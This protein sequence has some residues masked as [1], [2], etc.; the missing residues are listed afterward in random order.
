MGANSENS[1][2][3]STAIGGIL[4]LHTWVDALASIGHRRYALQLD[5]DGGWKSVDFNGGSARLGSRIW[6]I[7][8]VNL[9]ECLEVA[10]HVH[11]EYR[12]VEQRFPIATV[13]FKDSLGIRENTVHLRL[14]IKGLEVAVMIQLQPR[15]PAVIGIASRNTGPDSTHK[16]QF[17]SAFGMGIISDRFRPFFHL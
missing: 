17:P 12:N 9:V 15:D 1:G 3:S 6:K 5:G 13:R 16:Q 10:V 8:S 2:Q 14:K 7:L 4:N 11:K